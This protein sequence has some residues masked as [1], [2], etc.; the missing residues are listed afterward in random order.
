MSA[1][2]V[3]LLA[4]LGLGTWI[5]TKLQGETGYGNNRSAFIA[6]GV[7]FIIIFLVVFTIFQKISP[8]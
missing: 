3:A 6:T 7:A 1:F 4:S 8:H 2:F 5:F